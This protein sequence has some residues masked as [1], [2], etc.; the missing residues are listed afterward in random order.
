[1]DKIDIGCGTPESR[2]YAGM[3]LYSLLNARKAALR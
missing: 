3:A 1:M 2:D